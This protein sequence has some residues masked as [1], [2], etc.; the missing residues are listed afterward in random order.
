MK[1]LASFTVP[2][3]TAL[4]F[5]ELAPPRQKS[6]IVESLLIELMDEKEPRNFDK[7]WSGGQIIQQTFSIE[8]D[9]MTRF[10]KGA[11]NQSAILAHLIQNWIEKNEP[12]GS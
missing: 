1:V 7:V 5:D 2:Y 11:Y 12:K 6:R 4:R 10:R 8:F 9:V 3:S